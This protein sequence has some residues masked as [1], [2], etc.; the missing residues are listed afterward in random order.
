MGVERARKSKFFQ[1]PRPIN[2]RRGSSEFFQVPQKSGVMKTFPRW[3]P[4]IEG[5]KLGILLSRTAHIHRKVRGA[6]EIEIF[7]NLA[8]RIEVRRQNLA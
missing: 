6:G 1:V 7:R 4:F 2:R 3:H 5:G 8:A